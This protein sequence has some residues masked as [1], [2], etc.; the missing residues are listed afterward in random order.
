M[1]T[2]FMTSAAMKSKGGSSSAIITA[3]ARL[4]FL[5]G[6]TAKRLHTDGCKEQDTS[7]I[8][9]FLANQGTSHTKTALALSP[10]NAIV[11]R[12]FEAI[13]GN[14]RTSLLSVPPPLNQPVFWPIAALD[15]IDKSSHLPFIRDGILQTSPHTSMQLHVC[16]TDEI[17]GPRASCRT[18]SWVSSLTQTNSKINGNI[19]QCRRTIF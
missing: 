17:A 5:C 15:S 19:E 14:A 8:K 4:Q 13:F 1:G 10:S 11:E 3:L 6:I 18:A 7:D 16:N 9:K 12:R 2:G